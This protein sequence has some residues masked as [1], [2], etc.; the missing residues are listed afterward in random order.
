MQ[1][2]VKKQ[3][4]YT[5]CNMVPVRLECDVR[6]NVFGFRCSEKPYQSYLQRSEALCGHSSWTLR[7][8]KIR[9]VTSSTPLRKKLKTHKLPS[10]S[11]HQYRRSAPELLHYL[12]QELEPSCLSN[13]CDLLSVN[14]LHVP[15]PQ[16]RQGLYKQR[17]LTR[18]VS[19]ALYR[20]LW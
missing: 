18:P 16:S 14:H 6:C 20:Y 9:L 17:E 5:N 4:F 7:P 10:I 3:W 2:I 11:T 19:R 13:I 15:A 8:L 1:N 12:R